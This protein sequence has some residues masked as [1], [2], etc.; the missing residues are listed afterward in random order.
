MQTNDGGYYSDLRVY[1]VKATYVVY[2]KSK[3][4]KISSYEVEIESCPEDYFGSKNVVKNIE[5]SKLYC[6]SSIQTSLEDDIKDL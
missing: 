5:I 2:D 1:G 4:Q 3:E 6:L